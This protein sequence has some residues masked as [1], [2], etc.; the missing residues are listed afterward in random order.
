M[1]VVNEKFKNE[2]AEVA[3][4]VLGAVQRMFFENSQIYAALIRLMIDAEVDEFDL[5]FDD[6]IEIEANYSVAFVRASEDDD[7][8]VRIELRKHE[9]EDEEHNG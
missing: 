2:K 6:R 1:K 4:Y 8:T 5:S 7:Q 3:N 9:Y